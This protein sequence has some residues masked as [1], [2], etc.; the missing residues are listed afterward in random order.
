MPELKARSD[1]HTST[2]YFVVWKTSAGIF[3]RKIIQNPQEEF[4]KWRDG[5]CREDGAGRG[6]ASECETAT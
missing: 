4:V 1:G 3:P 2:K 6:S 5:N